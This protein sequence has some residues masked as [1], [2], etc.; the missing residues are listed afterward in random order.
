MRGAVGQL[1]ALA[2][3]AAT[4]APAGAQDLSQVF[5]AVNP[6]VVI[7]RTSEREV[8]AAGELAKFGEVGSGVLISSDGKVMTAQ[9]SHAMRRGVAEGGHG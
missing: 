8:S 9:R 1:V 7:V 6:S 3:I 2:W 4:A 5:K